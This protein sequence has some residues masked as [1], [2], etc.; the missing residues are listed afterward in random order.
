MKDKDL[1]GL[2][3]YPKTPLM[4]QWYRIKEAHRDCLIFFRLGDFYELFYDDAE[5]AAPLLNIT[6][7]SRDQGAEGRVP[8]CGV[9]YHAYESY[10]ARLLEKGYKVAI[11]EQ[12]EPPGKALVERQVVRILTPGTGVAGER[13]G[14]EAYL[15]AAI[16]L[17]GEGAA[18]ALVDVAT[19]AF[20]AGK[21]ASL[22]EELSLWP[23]AEVLLPKEAEGKGVG[24]PKGLVT[25]FEPQGALPPFPGE[26]ELDPQ[27]R[28]A[29]RLLLSYIQYTWK[30]YP[31]HLQAPDPLHQ[32][33]ELYLDPETRIHLEIFSRLDGRE[34]G[35]L[36][37][38]LNRTVT[39]GGSR[40]LRRW[41]SSPL[42]HRQP[43][44]ERLDAVA[45]WKE[46]AGV[47]R[48]ARLM[49]KDTYDLER[50]LSR[51]AAGRVT[52]RD[53][54]A[55]ADT[56]EKA[57]GL[58]DLLQGDG[59]P[60]LLHQAVETLKGG[61]YG[62]RDL[63]HR[64][65]SR[66]S[67]SDR[68]K[69]GYIRD[70]YD[71]ELDSWRHLMRHGHE[72]LLDLERREREATG[73]R[74][75]KVGFNKV[76]GYYIEVTHTH[77]DLV[78][79]RYIRKQTLAQAERYITPELKDLEEKLLHAE[80]AALSREEELFIQLVEE[81]A[82]VL[83]ALMDLARSLHLLDVT[84]ALG[85]VAAERRYERPLLVEEPVLEAL[86]ARHPVLEQV[87][88]REVC[89]PNPIAMTREKPFL[90]LTGPNMA[91]KSTYARTAA[92]LCLLAQVGSF[93]PASFARIGLADA[94]FTRI[95][96]RDDLAGGESTFMR[97]MLE[98]RR[99]LERATRESLV[100]VDEVGRGTSTYD[101]LALAWAVAEDLAERGCRTLFTTHFHELTELE[102]QHPAVK[103]LTMAVA[104]DREKGT[105]RFLYAVK[106]GAA[107]R[108]YG[109]HVAALAGL[110]PRLLERAAAILAHLEAR[111]GRALSH[112][113]AKDSSG[114]DW[115]RW[116]EAILALSLDDLS[117]R[118]AWELLARWQEQL[119]SGEV[120]T[121]G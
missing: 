117:P 23:V 37:W 94:I 40:L 83:P 92:L 119:L 11:C 3:P 108:S 53:L 101:G 106:E 84:A 64:A 78:P 4:R 6:L 118:Q 8:M 56:L 109:L 116:R 44:E 115:E 65:L 58:A 9:P 88:G 98:T 47:R 102:E 72:M 77:R 54:Q 97:E 103:N 42:R 104:E 52:P 14:E 90:L 80:E 74:S 105:L 29:C 96:A 45:F 87:L 79:P 89:V 30:S 12:M 75:L 7:T 113:R 15:A 51:T 36:F 22:S 20:Y 93:V 100:V 114:R 48:L 38:A 111:E 32:G 71:G 68:R 110:P 55:L 24:L 16:P 57:K 31:R 18:L 69:G 28:E 17:A 1:T 107:D 10:A 91:G 27:V 43:L 21:V 13:E 70:G 76:F 34:E 121:R 60:A 50:I 66:P 95:G 33:R 49:L 99:I 82:R 5:I 112:P 59:L 67:P 35:T 26:E 25:Y 73:I 81:V 41:L 19:G 85:E 39:R 2:P 120:P 62:L 63:L 86:D 61:P 46:H